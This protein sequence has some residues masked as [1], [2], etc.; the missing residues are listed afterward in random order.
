MKA[1]TQEY[2]SVIIHTTIKVNKHQT[3]NVIRQ[4]FKHR[5]VDSGNANELKTN[6]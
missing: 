2:T 4:L 6:C 3:E 1:K 5:A